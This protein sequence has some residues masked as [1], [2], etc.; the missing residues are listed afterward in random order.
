MNHAQPDKAVSY[1]TALQT[2]KDDDRLR[3]LKPRV[4]IDFA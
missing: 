4:G 1:I 3:S 2:L